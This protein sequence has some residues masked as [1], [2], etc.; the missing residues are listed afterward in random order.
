M[1]QQKS[2]S[3]II[4]I[5]DT[6]LWLN[7]KD[8]DKGFLFGG[9]AFDKNPPTKL[10]KWYKNRVQWMHDKN[11]SNP[12]LRDA[13]NY[14]YSLC[15]GRNAAIAENILQ[16][17]GGNVIYNPTTGQLLNGLEFPE[18]EF[19]VGSLGA[20]MQDGDTV[21]VI[22]DARII[23]GTVDITVDGVEIGVALLDRFSYTYTSTSTQIVITFNQPVLDGQN[24]I[25]KYVR[26]GQVQSSVTKSTQP[27][28]SV[29]PSE[30][31][32]SFQITA[33]QGV[34]ITDIIWVSRA[35][36]LRRVVPSATNDMMEIEYVQATN[37]FVLPIGD[38]ATGTEDF[39]ISYMV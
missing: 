27:T 7:N 33:L 15:T 31:T 5:A 32:T 36:I 39:L 24:I 9:G 4:N 12:T 29:R 38:T 21:L 8:V 28:I 16:Q 18:L 14:L 11:P 1:V 20:P 35:G 25:V 26:G 37:T 34:P 13:A 2:I 17:Q 10:L 19:V 3:T 23:A 6:C 22:N 30:G